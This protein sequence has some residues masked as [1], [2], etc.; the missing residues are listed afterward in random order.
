M[1]TWT[2]RTVAFATAA[3]VCALVAPA[4]A[5]AATTNLTERDNGRT[6]AVYPGDRI[7]LK[8]ASCE[9]SCGYSWTTTDTPNKW[10]LPTTSSSLAGQVRTFGYRA[11]KSGKT[12][13]RLSYDPPGA[14]QPQKHF[15]LRVQVKRSFDMRLRHGRRKGIRYLMSP[16]DR[17]VV[18]LP[19]CEASC[20]YS[21]RTFDAP[22]RRI[23]RRTSTRLI[24]STRRD[25]RRIVY[26]A[27][28]RGTTALALGYRPPGSG[29]AEKMFRITVRV[30]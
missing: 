25:Y 9:A 14:A 3:A 26:R 28:S 11:R 18:R 13:L 1:R 19:S 8:L 21:W 5:S 12:S 16:G 10:V 15:T 29:R 30:R 2:R 17:I 22:N 27:G 23:L 20:G 7:S 4:A 6:I 24:E